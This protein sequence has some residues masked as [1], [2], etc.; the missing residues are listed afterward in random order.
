MKADH[1]VP[2][3]GGRYVAKKETHI[4][5]VGAAVLAFLVVYVAANDAKLYYAIA[6]GIFMGSA[7]YFAN[8]LQFHRENS[9]RLNRHHSS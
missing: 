4:F 7:I 8:Y 5:S 2:R 1:P 6:A 9:R 3:N